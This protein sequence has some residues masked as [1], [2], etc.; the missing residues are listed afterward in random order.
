MQ[1]NQ[2]PARLWDYGSVYIS[3]TQSILTRGQNKRPGLERLTCETID[4]SECLDFDFYDWVWYWDQKK[5][6]M[7]EEQAKIGCW[8]GIEHRVGSDMT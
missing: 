1:S 3:E 2:V 4:I 5:M 6:D 7:T 8:L